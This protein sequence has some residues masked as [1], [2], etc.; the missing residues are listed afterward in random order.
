M[1]NKKI[2]P[3]FVG[4]GIVFVLYTLSLLMNFLFNTVLYHEEFVGT[5]GIRLAFRIKNFTVLALLFM[6]IIWANLRVL[7]YAWKTGD[8]TNLTCSLGV[9]FLVL[10]IFADRMTGCFTVSRF[11]NGRYVGLDIVPLMLILLCTVLALI[12]MFRILGRDIKAV[13]N[14]GLSLFALFAFLLLLEAF[15]YST[16]VN[17]LKPIPVYFF[18]RSSAPLWRAM[19]LYP[20]SEPVK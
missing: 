18:L 16:Y 9:M 13:T 1:T 20:H 10:M 17:V 11:L 15:S 7:R 4:F 6:M 19:R 8:R 3:L 12:L 14:W 5:P 2:D